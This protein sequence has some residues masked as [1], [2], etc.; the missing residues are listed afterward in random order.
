MYIA[1]IAWH[2]YIAK[3]FQDAI[4]YARNT[5]LRPEEISL[6]IIKIVWPIYKNKIMLLFPICLK[7]KYH[8]LNF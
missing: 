3:E 2:P 4:F 1:L 7:K 8:P 5:S 6:F